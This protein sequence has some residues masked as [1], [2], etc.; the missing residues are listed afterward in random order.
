MGRVALLESLP[1]QHAFRSLRRL[2]AKQSREQKLVH[3]HLEVGQLKYD[4]E[5]L[6][7]EVLEW[8]SLFAQQTFAEAS[9]PR[10]FSQQADVGLQKLLQF[11]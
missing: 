3:L 1:S 2:Q 4:W 11:V 5:V 7:A 10:G 9:D 8:R 6:H